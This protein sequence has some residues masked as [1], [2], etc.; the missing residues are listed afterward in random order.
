MKGVQARRRDDGFR[1]S[2]PTEQWVTNPVRN[3]VE[4]ASDYLLERCCEAEW[5]ELE[6]NPYPDDEGLEERLQAVVRALNGTMTFGGET[7]PTPESLASKEMQEPEHDS[8]APTAAQA[9][10]LQAANDYLYWL[11]ED[12]DWVREYRTNIP[13]AMTEQEMVD[14]LLSPLSQVLS[15]D[16]FRELGLSPTTTC[17]R[18]TITKQWREPEPG[19]TKADRERARR[20][21][22]PLEVL[23][24]EFAVEVDGPDGKIIPLTIQRKGAPETFSYYSSLL[25]EDEEGL[26]KAGGR[27]IEGFLRFDQGRLGDREA[28]PDFPFFSFMAYPQS[29]GGETNGLANTIRENDF[30][31]HFDSN[32]RFILMHERRG[33]LFSLHQSSRGPYVPQWQTWMHTHSH[34]VVPHWIM[35]EELADFWRRARPDKARERRMPSAANTELFRFVLYNT[36]LGSEPQWASLARGGSE[37]SG[38]GV[39]RDKLYKVY[40]SVLRALFPEH[41]S[42]QVRANIRPW[43]RLPDPLEGEGAEGETPPGGWMETETE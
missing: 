28:Y 31:N 27:K 22:R 15:F 12:W 6:Q 3:R 35:P 37:L 1:Q 30:C 24:T 8:A 25:D 33:P 17:G 42:K 19:V 23:F 40:H 14:F 38:E 11:L 16:D 39:T 21:G 2:V 36:P 18:A 26:A 34:L 4:I 32:L 13:T 41:P 9:V 20:R 7:S 29:V 10:Y 43:P 5:E